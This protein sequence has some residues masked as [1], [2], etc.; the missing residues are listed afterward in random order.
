[1]S[2]LFVNVVLDVPRKPIKQQTA[3]YY[4]RVGSCSMASEDSRGWMVFSKEGLESLDEA[5]LQVLQVRQLQ[6]G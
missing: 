1:M 2:C 4:R 6:T 3:V 5:S